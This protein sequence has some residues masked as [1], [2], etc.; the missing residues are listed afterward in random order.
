MYI[1][2]TLLCQNFSNILENIDQFLWLESQLL[3]K[4]HNTVLHFTKFTKKRESETI[5]RIAVFMLNLN[6]NEIFF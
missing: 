4:S 5:I 3:P 6:L 2:W 1:Y